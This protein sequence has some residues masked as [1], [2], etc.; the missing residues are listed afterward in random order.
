MADITD[1]EV[2]QGETF[3]ILLHIYTEATSSTLLDITDYTFQGQLRENYT[4]E[5][6]AATFSVTKIPPYNSGS[7]YVTLGS[8]ATAPLTQ[9]TYVYDLLMSSGSNPPV[10]RRMLEGGFT[11]RPA[12]TR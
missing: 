9:R 2:G 12:V 1:F 6:V 4:T 11:I 5:E 8:D 10:V 7:V 3:K